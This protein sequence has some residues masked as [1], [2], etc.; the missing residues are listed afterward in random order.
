M[1]IKYEYS[2]DTIK[3]EIICGGWNHI[4]LYDI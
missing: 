3:E 4:L 1:L 2:N